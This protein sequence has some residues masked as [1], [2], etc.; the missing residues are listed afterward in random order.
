MGSQEVPS[1]DMDNVNIAG[2]SNGAALTYQIMINTGADRPFKRALPMVSSLIGPQYHEDQ[3][4]TFSQSARNM[5][6]TTLTS[7][8]SPR[9]RRTLSTPTIR[10]WGQNPGPGFLAGAEVYAAQLTDFI[11][12]RA[13]GYTGPQLDD[14]EGVD[15]G[16]DGREAEEYKY[17]SGRCRHYKLI[18]ETHGS[19]GPNHPVVQKVVRE[20]ILGE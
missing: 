7:R 12:A 14:S 1:A 18:G 2:T 4:W 5:R 19:A 13:M 8:R 16:L 9:S 10:Y 3:F 6:L 17:L 20:L 11:W 15:V